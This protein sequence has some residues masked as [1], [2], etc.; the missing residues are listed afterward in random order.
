MVLMHSDL[1]DVV[2]ALR[3][4]KATLKNIKQNLFWALFYNAICIPVAAG[5][6]YPTFDL[7]LNPMIG[8]LA[9]SFSSVFVVTNA[10]RLRFVKLDGD[11]KV[12]K[13][14]SAEEKTAEVDMPSKKILLSVEGMMCQHCVKRVSDALS[15][16]EGVKNVEVNLESQS[17]T[18][19][20]VQNQEIA[21]LIQAVEEVGYQV[22]EKEA[23]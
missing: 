4:G 13:S 11:M 8:D 5:V 1:T 2:R 12:T 19:E 17:A 22:G 23:I 14:I 18:V 16:V 6:F 7:K 20:M 21:P 3:L 10:L 15:N 9:M